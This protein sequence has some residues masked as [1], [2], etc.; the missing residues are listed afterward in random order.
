MLPRPQ[1][2]TASDSI[3]SQ[4]SSGRFQRLF[5]SEHYRKNKHGVTALDHG[6]VA[7]NRRSRCGLVRGRP[8]VSS[9]CLPGAAPQVGQGMASILL[10][11]IVLIPGQ[12]IPQDYAV[13]KR[14]KPKK[15]LGDMS[16]AP[17]KY[18]E[19]PCSCAGL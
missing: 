17:E 7:I 11:L 2:M 10:G 16:P 12:M 5:N 13:N 15:R 6:S 9:H 8:V 18:L 14:H 4:T 19:G 3:Y 1:P